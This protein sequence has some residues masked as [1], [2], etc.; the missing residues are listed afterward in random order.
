M[1][2]IFVVQNVNGK[3]LLP[4][5]EFGKIRVMLTGNEPIIE[6]QG[7]LR[8]IIE[9]EMGPDDY[10]LI[11]GNPL[12]IGI[13]FTYALTRFHTVKFLQWDRIEYKYHERTITI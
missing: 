10:I 2:T 3:N 6:A 11:I 9:E 5:K 8:W 12:F 13:A 4:A 1:K 7:K